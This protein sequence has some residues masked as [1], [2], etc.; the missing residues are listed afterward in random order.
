MYPFPAS[1]V[2]AILARYPASADLVWVQEEP[3]NMGAWRFVQEQ[4]QTI[5]E[6]S[7]RAIRYIGRVESASTSSGSLKR[8]QQEQAEIV[9]LSFAAEIRSAVGRRRNARR[10]R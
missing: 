6:H 4:M 10:R 1:G 5:L 8:H 7:R 9:E 2:E 3:R